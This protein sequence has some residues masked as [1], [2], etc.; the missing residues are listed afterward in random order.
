MKIMIS[1]HRNFKLSGYDKEWIQE[2]IEEAIVFYPGRAVCSKDK[3]I[4][5][6][7]AAD[8]VDLWYLELL[9]SHLLDYHIYIPFEEQDLYMT[10]KDA[11]RRK[12]FIGEARITKKAR[13]RE[14]VEDC[15][16]AIVVWD[17]TKGGTFNCFQQL[18]EAK[19]NIYWINPLTKVIN[20]IKNKP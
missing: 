2:Q 11:E 7:G 6:C 16:E 12:Y 19:K 20:Y 14:M 4:G 13:N 18:I 17:G 15:N 9:H 10:K 1:G 3:Y 5:L 8:G